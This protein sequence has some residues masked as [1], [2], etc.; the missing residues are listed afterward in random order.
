M[1]TR[2]VLSMFLAA[3]G[4]SLI[5]KISNP[6][7]RASVPHENYNGFFGESILVAPREFV[8]TDLQSK[9][10]VGYMIDWFTVSRLRGGE[11]D[12]KY[13]TE[14]FGENPTVN[15]SR[16]LENGTNRS[17]TFTASVP[18]QIPISAPQN[19]KPTRDD[20]PNFCKFDFS[21]RFCKSD[22]SS[23][24]LGYGPRNARHGAF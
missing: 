16:L 21:V 9:R 19:P 3:S 18:S 23:R 15:G 11:D 12:I 22:C 20:S 5:I 14:K 13:Q 1:A 10:R 8:K 24:S 7:S 17:P 2:F 4:H 6:L